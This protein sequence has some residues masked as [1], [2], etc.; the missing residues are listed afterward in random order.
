[1]NRFIPAGTES[2]RAKVDADATVGSVARDNFVTLPAWFSVQQ[3]R[4]V[5]RLKRRAQVVLLGKRGIVHVATD[6]TLA[7]APDDSL[8]VS[9][10][11][12]LGPPLTSDLPLD[13]ALS[14]MESHRADFAAVV[15]DGV[16]VGIVARDEVCDALASAVRCQEASASRLAA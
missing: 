11:T 3:A 15:V 6:A 1:M 2:A 10:S 16:L 7:E 4:A 12:R 5:L 8:L 13:E 14:R 9:C